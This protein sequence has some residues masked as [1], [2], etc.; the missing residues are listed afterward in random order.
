MHRCCALTPLATLAALTLVAC[1]PAAKI[2]NGKQ[3]AAEALYAA[4]L[5]TSASADKA[6]TPVDLTG[7]VTWSCPQGGT[8]QLSGFSAN[9][10]V[11]GGA[12]IGTK[13]TLTYKDCG[14]AK[15]DVGVARY[16]GSFA[17]TKSV[18]AT[19]GTV[20]I[21]QAF[22]GKVMV[23]GAF[24]DFLDADVTQSLQ[25]SALNGAGAVSMTLKG[26]VAVS[27][28]SYVFDEAVNVTAGQLSVAVA[29]K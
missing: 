5:P 16:N 27:S 23:Q 26:T 6:A 21:D 28:G 8:A 1:G 4:S 22:K 10:V 9:L 20:S 13:Y 11:G 2:G 14:L 19:A 17:V 12:T 3:G 15:G 18:L 24:D 29:K 7:D 25:A